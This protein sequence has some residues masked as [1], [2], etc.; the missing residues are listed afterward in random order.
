MAPGLTCVTTPVT[1][2]KDV[3]CYAMLCSCLP[4]LQAT[5]GLAAVARVQ[6]GSVQL[7]AAPWDRKGDENDGK[8]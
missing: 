2:Y 7:T 8:T 1:T 4:E 5:A 3:L 6:S